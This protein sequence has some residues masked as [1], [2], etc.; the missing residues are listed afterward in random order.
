[1]TATWEPVSGIET[2]DLPF[3]RNRAHCSARSACTDAAAQR[4]ECPDALVVAVPSFHE[5]F[6]ANS[7]PGGT[8]VTLRI[9][10]PARR[11]TTSRPGPGR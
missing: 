2:A 6:G 4:P 10:A 7:E 3:T 9:T 8:S 5:S 11:W 1:M